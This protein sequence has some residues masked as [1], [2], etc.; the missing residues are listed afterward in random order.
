MA[1]VMISGNAW[2]H[3]DAPV[4]AELR[5]E[6][7]FRPREAGRRHGLQ[8]NREV[9]ATLADSGWFSVALESDVVYV[10]FM[11]WLLDRY[12]Q[13]ETVPNRSMGYCEWRMFTAVA[14][15]LIDEQPSGHTG[16]DLWWVSLDPPPAGFDGF[17]LH[18][19]PTVTSKD[20]DPTLGD[21]ERVY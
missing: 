10:P 6:L 21:I 5:P 7:W 8:T 3:N 20:L 17:W 9:R 18:T 16:D 19:D 13:D 2:D 4:P 11:R 12:Q 14:D 15:G 1:T